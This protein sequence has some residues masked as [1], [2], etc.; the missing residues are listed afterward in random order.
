[1]GFDRQLA[2]QEHHTFLH[3][4]EA[5][6]PGRRQGGFRIEPAAL[7]LDLNAQQIRGR[8]DPY[9]Y[10]RFPGMAGDVRQRFLHDPVGRGLHRGCEPSFHSLVLEVDLHPGL[11]GETLEEREQRGQQPE[12][13]QR[14]RPQ[15]KR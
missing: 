13:I 3:P 12:L 10:I 6:G 9:G 7:I 8:P 14:G 5:A 11:F 1:V 4:G 2:V 15:V